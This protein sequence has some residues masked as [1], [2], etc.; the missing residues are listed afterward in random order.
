[1]GNKKKINIILILFVVCLWGTVTYKWVSRFI[2][3][4]DRNIHDNYVKKNNNYNRIR[5]DTF[6]LKAIKRDPFLN[7]LIQIEEPIKTI[8]AVT[9]R[10]LDA[11]PIV[12]PK[13]EKIINWPNITYHG[14]IKSKERL[15]VLVLVQIDGRVHKLKKNNLIGDLVLKNIY[16]DSLEFALEN[17][18][19]IIKKK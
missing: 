13:I 12:I 14:Y 17:K 7:I 10:K 4:E 2:K 11:K 9:I 5:K 19:K 8:P 15:E 18:I 6:E 1:M 3:K 16:D